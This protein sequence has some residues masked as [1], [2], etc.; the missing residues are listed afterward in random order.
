MAGGN[1]KLVGYGG[2]DYL[3]GGDG[4][5]TLNGGLGADTMVGGIG[6]D[7]YWVD[8][9]GDVNPENPDEGTDRVY[10]AI[11]HT[12]GNALE[13]LTLT[14]ADNISGVGNDPDNSILGNSGDNLLEGGIGNDSLNGGLGCRHHDRRHR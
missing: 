3:D 5:D 10:A 7:K 9:V 4:D 11:S 13:N 8:N 12:L 1:D 6:N 2:D 14:A